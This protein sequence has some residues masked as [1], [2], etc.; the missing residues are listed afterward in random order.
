[1]SKNLTNKPLKGASLS[2]NSGTFDVVQANSIILPPETLDGLVTGTQLAGVTIIDS[3]IINSVIGADGPNEGHFTRLTSQDDITFRTIDGTKSATWDAINGIFG[4]DGAFYVRDCSTLGNLG[5]CVNTIRALNSNGDIN[6]I[7]K[8]SG[9]LY[10]TGPISNV[11]ASSGNYLTSL[12][13]G[14]I[15]FLSSDYINL[16]SKSAGATLTSFSDQVF[17]TV[18]G[19]ITLNTETGNSTKL[20]TSI[21][22]SQGNTIVRTVTPSALRVGDSI[23]LSNTNSIPSLDG[24]FTVKSIINSTNFV[25]STGSLFSG[26]LT[27]GTSGILYKPATNNINLNAAVFVKIP[28]NILLT[29]GNTTNSVSG[30]S[31]GLYINSKG[32]VIYNISSSN[33]LRLPQTTKFQLGTSG[34][35]YINFDGNSLNM[36][37]SNLVNITGNETYINSSSIFLKDADPLFANYT[38]TFSDISDRGFQFNYYDGGATS[39]STK[40]G[41]FGMK[42]DTG[43]FTFLRNVTNVNDVFTGTLGDFEIGP[44]ASTS[45]TIS[46]GSFINVNCGYLYN[47]NTITG[48]GNVLNINAANTVNITAASRIALQSA[49]DI[50]I[51]NN[52]PITFGTSGSYIKEGTIGNMWINA[53]KNIMLN[54]QTIGSVIIQPNVKI[55]FDGTSVGNAS[56]SSDTNGNLN[57]NTNKNINL[58]T[59]AG[60]III[61]QNTSGS[62]A[63]FPS[64]QFG[65]TFLTTIT[66]ATETIS[67]STKGIFII[68]N[69]SLGSV[70]TIATSNV[71]ISTSSGNVL[72]N[73]YNGDINLYATSGNITTGGNIRLYQGSRVV[74]GISGT[75]N[76]IRSNSSG[77]LLINGPNTLP[78]TGTIGNL[79]ELQN[80]A[81][82]NLRAANTVNIPTAVQFNLDNTSTRYLIADTSSNFNLINSNSSSGNI[83]VTALTTNIM[84]TSGSVNILNTNTNITTS[85]FTLTGNTSSNTIINTQNVKLYDPILTIANYTSASYDNRDRGIEYTYTNTAGSNKLGW[86]G[87][88]SST[89]QFTFYS[90]AVNT[91][92][93]ISGTLGQILLGNA[94]ISNSLSFSSTGNINLNCGTISNMNTIIGCSGVVNVLG[95]NN[96]NMSASNINLMSNTTGRVLIPLNVPLSFGSTSNNINTDSSGNITI[97]SNNGSGTLVLNANVQINGTTESIYST[98]T[99]IQDPIISIGGVT[100]PVVNDLKDRGIE[101]KW[102]GTRNGVTGSKTGFFG[103]DNS[104]QRFIFI[105]DS[106]NTDDII[107]GSAGDVQFANGYYNNLDVNCGTIA[108]VA[109]I[110][111]CAGQGLSFVSSSGN[112]NISSSSIIIPTNSTLGFGTSSNSIS[113]DTSGNIQIKSANNTTITSNSGGIIFN[114]NTS[115]TGFTQFI[116]NSPMYFGS[117]TNGNFFKRDTSGNFIIS[118]TSGDIYLN[119]L[120]DSASGSFGSV[121]IPTND[122]LVFGSQTTRIESDTSGNLNIYGWSIGINSTNSIIFNGNVDIVGNFNTYD[123][124]YI[125]PLGTRQK[126]N[127]TNIINSTTSGRVLITT[128]T[129]HYLVVNDKVTIVNSNSIPDVNGEYT[130]NQIISD[131][132]FSI[133]HAA[134]STPGSKGNMYGVLKVYQ[135]KDIGIEVDYW[136]TVGNTS[137]TAGSVN[138][139]TAFFG[140]I[141]NTQ[142]WTYYSNAT[143]DNF[144]VTNGILGNLRANKVN[145]N[146]MSGF[147]LDGAISGGSNA[148]IGSNFSI[149]GGTIDSTPIGQSAAQ[150]GRFTSLA[151]TVITNLKNVTLQSNLNYSV[152][153]FE[154]AS[155][156][157][158]SRNPDLSTVITY[159]S[160]S[161]SGFTGTGNMLTTGV[162]DGQVKK[163]ICNNMGNNCQYELS[164]ASGK[165]I[166]PNP[167]GGAA[168]TKLT[169]KR[170]GQSCELTWDASLNAST[171]AWLLTGGTGAYVS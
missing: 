61:P 148:I 103:F 65:G 91:N 1:M 36:N 144:V 21:F 167:L 14:N 171:G 38:Q 157:S 105:P 2:I 73:T 64:I 9:T 162:Y 27:N 5:I 86:F 119:P 11:V 42:K 152:D 33:I 107:N 83:N 15:T 156:A 51:P 96:I 32:D 125:Y 48:C 145:T 150:S 161:G 43:R 41:W 81:V 147:V 10:F 59:T 104:S 3:T 149:S 53:S 142:E 124:T 146:N 158:P 127:I 97:T 79:I 113:A 120:K 133:P 34:S 118:N 123:G 16:T 26:I 76:S 159:V 117:S 169:F 58:I 74:F 134:L 151:S 155:L 93:V 18:N 95:T 23:V 25:V 106:T 62:A 84:N 7:P 46:S 138:Y 28:S 40:L 50:Y 108:N 94:V 72:I 77:N 55:S 49:G 80:A 160:V 75:S 165:L 115:G 131:Y 89:G 66:T 132:I 135:G 45:I 44:I 60:N 54:T 98:V 19:D 17:T 22:Q 170:R 92:E 24:T 143:I 71:N 99:T 63:G 116:T 85:T 110:T 56:I 122:K 163:I 31:G 141:N 102:Y 8:G 101:F 109:V 12:N 153:R 37:S 121:I 67:G 128:D 47:V 13:N 140:W 35:N 126:T 112:I 111:A 166:A 69:S 4:V 78:N 90:D 39:G 88:K 87:Y 70:N 68:S 52:I 57:L 114:T 20:I 137:V 6:L 164:F 130:V 100:G 139:K 29:F 129:P 154:L 136:S 168:P 82:I 30:N